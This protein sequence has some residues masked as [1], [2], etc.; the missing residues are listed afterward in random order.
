MSE[1]TPGP[2]RL[3]EDMG[4]E[5]YSDELHVSFISGD[6]THPADDRAN[7]ALIVATRNA[8]LNA[9]SLA[10]RVHAGWVGEL[11]EAVKII[12]NPTPLLMPPGLFDAWGKQYADAMQTVQSLLAEAK[13]ATP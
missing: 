5:I 2:W 6:D 8:F 13:G 12:A 7:A 11:V 1:F 3:G 9:E 10:L 4:A